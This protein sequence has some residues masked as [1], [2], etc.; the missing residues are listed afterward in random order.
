M[1]TFCRA[2]CQWHSELRQGMSYRLSQVHLHFQ[3][4]D[5]CA[6]GPQDLGPPSP[7]YWKTKVRGYGD[8]LLMLNCMRSLLLS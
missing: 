2:E 3:K 6:V 8:E 7:L 5:D 4:S 1:L